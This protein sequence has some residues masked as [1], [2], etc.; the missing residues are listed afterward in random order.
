MSAHRFL[1]F[2]LGAETGRAVV[3]TLDRDR[4][5]LEEIHR[6]PNEPVEVCGTLH[7]DV[8]N[9][10][11][12]LLKGMRAY[13]ERYGSSVDG[14]GIDTWGVDFGLLAA[15]GSLLQNPVHYRD[16]RTEDVLEYIDPRMSPEQRF[17]LTGMCAC[18]IYTLCQMVA[19]QRQQSPILA[20]A[21]TFLMMP[22]LLAYFLTGRK[23]CERTAAVTTQF[24]DAQHGVWHEEIL[25]AF[26]LPRAIMPE[27]VDPGT[28]LGDLSESVARQT[29][30]GSAPVIAPC[31]HDTAS[32]VAAV[33]GKGDN[34]AFISSGTWSVLGALT[35][36]AIVSDDAFGA[37]MCNELTLDRL[38]LC[39]NIMGLW[40][41]QQVRAVWEQGGQTYS[42]EDLVK[43]AEQA[44]EDGALIWP[45][46]P[47]FLAPKDMVQ[48]IRDYC[49][50]TAQIPP[51]GPA[52][53]TR[54]ILES[55]ALCYRHGLE[56]LADMLSRDFSLLH[57]VGGGSRNAL[58]CQLT[59]DAADVPVLAG[60]VEATV[61]GNVLVQARARGYLASPEEIREV[62][63][64]SFDLQEY[65]P[66]HD[67]RWEERYEHYLSLATRMED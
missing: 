61:A 12:S 5:S 60:P 47:S 46:H 65:E 39:R 33:P 21:A 41:L 17:Q 59:A 10:Y 37:G 31:A 14:I 52:E 51:D 32:A 6:F 15:D 22:D 43:L 58:L 9:L 25:S 57:I 4:L 44:P 24:Y 7:W 34:W 49:L 62:V 16:R 45:D 23:V 54:C 66:H 67:R 28:V 63:R 55:L 30:L 19:L 11:N 40:L 20:S 35:D 29:G 42:Y 56:G 18:P 64:A 1:A 8:L 2:D 36:E 38:F 48:A 26:G 53:T 13:S 27:L 50:A 3:G